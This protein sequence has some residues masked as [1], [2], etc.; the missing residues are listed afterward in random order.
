MKQKL[1]ILKLM[2]KHSYGYDY[3]T[4]IFTSNEWRFKISS[5]SYDKL[6]LIAKNVRELNL[7]K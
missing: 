4:N 5:D 2:C 6:I 3:D 1:L 7:S